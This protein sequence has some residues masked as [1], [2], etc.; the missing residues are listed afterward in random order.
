M[1]EEVSEGIYAYVQPDGSWYINNTGFLLG[2]DGAVSIDTCSTEQRTRAYLAAIA[3]VTDLPVRTLVKPTTTVTT[4]TAI[5]SSPGPR[6]SHTS[7]AGRR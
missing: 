3:A 4:P 2:A 7:A 6:S 5:I 1:V